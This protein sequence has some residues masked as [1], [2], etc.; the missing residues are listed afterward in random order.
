MYCA[1]I[2]YLHNACYLILF[3]LVH[4]PVH[5]TSSLF[6]IRGI[7]PFSELR[8][9]TDQLNQY[10]VSI[11]PFGIGLSVCLVNIFDQTYVIVKKF[12]GLK[13]CTLRRIY[14]IFY[15]FWDCH[16]KWF[17]HCTNIRS[18]SIIIKLTFLWKRYH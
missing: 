1:I 11:S 4:K 5:F 9:W 2:N 10:P 18:I 14:L 13:L 6:E 16:I 8:N 3:D 7:E 15:G 17:L 12:K